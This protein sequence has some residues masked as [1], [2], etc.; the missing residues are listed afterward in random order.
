MQNWNTFKYE[1][2]ISYRSLNKFLLNLQASKAI[3]RKEN[4]KRARVEWNF[5]YTA[6]QQYVCKCVLRVCVCV[7]VC[8]C[9]CEVENKQFYS[10]L[11][12][13]QF[14]FLSLCPKPSQSRLHKGSSKHISLVIMSR[15]LIQKMVRKY[16]RDSLHSACQVQRLHI[17]L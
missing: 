14:S 16:R 3:C 9:S 12:Y 11:C 6:L 17:L 10:L 4:V 13:S 7:C 2:K 15:R 8:V 1:L 5:E